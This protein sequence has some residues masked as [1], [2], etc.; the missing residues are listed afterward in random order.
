M[1]KHPDYSPHSPH[2][3]TETRPGYHSDNHAYHEE[4]GAELGAIAPGYSGI[5][6]R[7]RYGKRREARNAVCGSCNW[8]GSTCFGCFIMVSMAGFIRGNSCNRRF[9]G[10]SPRC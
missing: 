7:P 6:C 10:F 5:I 3:D 2:D 8:V 9:Y 4:M 1:N